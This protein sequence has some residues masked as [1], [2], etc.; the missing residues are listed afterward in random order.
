MVGDESIKLRHLDFQF[1]QVNF[2]FSKTRNTPVSRVTFVHTK[3][4][5]LI[6]VLR[7]SQQLWPRGTLPLFYSTASQH[8][9]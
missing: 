6:V 3:R 7:T 8:W 9:G 4:I 2:C 1:L 5:S